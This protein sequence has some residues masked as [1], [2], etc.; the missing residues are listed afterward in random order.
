MKV[1]KSYKIGTIKKKL[2]TLFTAIRFA[3]KNKYISKDIDL[4]MPT[5][6]IPYVEKKF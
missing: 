1:V 2:A 6:S 3:K 4:D 5:I